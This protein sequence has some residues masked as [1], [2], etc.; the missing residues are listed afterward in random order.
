M[1]TNTATWPV[2]IGGASSGPKMSDFEAVPSLEFPALAGSWLA[3]HP[4][5]LGLS[6]GYV[7]FAVTKGSATVRSE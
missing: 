3:D 2:T 6:C 4:D 1:G 5:A 7:L